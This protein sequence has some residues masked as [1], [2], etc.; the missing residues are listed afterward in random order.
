VELRTLPGAPTGNYNITAKRIYRSS[1]GTSGTAYQFVAEVSI[2]TASYDDTKTPDQL[3]ETVATWNWEMLPVGAKGLVLMANGIGVAFENNELF[4]SE[5]YALYAYPPQYNLSTDSPIVGLGVFG[6]SCFVGTRANPYVLTGVDPSAMTF[7]RLDVNQACASKRSIVSM[8]GGVVYATPDGLWLVDNS[9]MRSLSEGLI[10][11][12]QWQT[13]NPP[14]FH[15]YELDG[16][17]IAFFDTGGRQGGLVFDFKHGNLYEI[18]QYCTAAYNDPLK[19]KLYITTSTTTIA[20]WDTST[21]PLVM[22]WKSKIYRSPDEIDIGYGKVEA[23]NYPLTLKLY[24]GITL[25][26][27]YTVQNNKP[28]RIM[29]S[30]V[31]EFQFEIEANGPV[32]AVVLTETGQEVMSG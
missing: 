6:Q 29:R 11:R 32:S 21:S 1:T 23:E 30:R 25:Y 4:L 19:D 10:S 20:S 16:R 3:G 31:K 5:P 14:S 27:T 13:Y 18:S 8:M 26:A 12:D 24:D 2:G 22:S 15:S 17:Y 28:F 7:T 9:G